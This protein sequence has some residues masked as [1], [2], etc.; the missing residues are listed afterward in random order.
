MAR[1]RVVAA[2]VLMISVALSSFGFHRFLDTD[3]GWWAALNIVMWIP[4]IS[5]ALI[6]FLSFFA[7]KPQTDG[8]F[9]IS[10]AS[11]YGKIFL[12]FLDSVGAKMFEN[13]ND[14]T[15]FCPVFWITNATIAMLG[16]LLGIVAIAISQMLI[17]GLWAT[18][19]FVAKV[20]GVFALVGG[21]FVLLVFGCRKAQD[22]HRALRRRSSV[23]SLLARLTKDTL[24][25]L[26]GVLLIEAGIAVVYFF[27]WA[28]FLAFLW[29]AIK[30]IVLICVGIVA[31]LAAIYGVCRLVAKTSRVLSETQF[32]KEFGSIYETYLC[33]RIKLEE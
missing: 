3:L 7:I 6:L 4:I 25:A 10:D 12:F 28:S 21:A 8:S 31:L 27:G 18:L 17:H 22:A 20:L 23:Y 19:I 24:L 2:L 33:P 9:A 16:F 32:G 14:R 13:Y 26:L 29:W 15:S 5:S 11:L 30:R 1:F